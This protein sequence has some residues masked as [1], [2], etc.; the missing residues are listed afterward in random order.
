MNDSQV[1]TYNL[2][3]QVTTDGGTVPDGGLKPADYGFT[4]NG[5][6][7]PAD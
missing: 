7:K 1:T 2:Q 4:H 6:L 5:G 3:V